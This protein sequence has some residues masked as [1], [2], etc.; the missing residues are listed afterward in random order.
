MDFTLFFA[1]FSVLGIVYFAVGVAASKDVHTE[2]DYFLANRQF[3]VWSITLTLIATQVGAGMLVGASSEAYQYGY[4]G[5]M[6]NAGMCLGFLLLGLGAASKLRGFNISTTAEI[7]EKMY[8]SRA[9]RQIASLL[10]IITLGGIFASQILASRKMIGSFYEGADG[11]ILGFWALVIIYTMFGGLRAV[12]A[13]DILQVILIFVI[14]TGALYW[15]I[16]PTDAQW[17]S[18]PQGFSDADPSKYFKFLLIPVLFAFIEQDLAQRFFSAKTK[19]VAVISA[20]LA[21]VIVLA[22]SFIPVYLG[23]KAKVMGLVIPPSSSPLLILIQQS[24]NELVLIFV[25]CALIAAI[26]STA[27]SLLCAVG[28]NIVNDFSRRNGLAISRAAT[29]LVGGIALIFAYQMDNVLETL[30]VSYEI[31]VSCLF[32]AIFTCFFKAKL[33]PA[34]AWMSVGLGF[35]GF[36]LFRAVDP[37][38]PPIVATLLLSLSG[39]IFGEIHGRRSDQGITASQ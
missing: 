6:Y 24:T 3:G 32:I 28:S 29:L 38:M 19:R 5:I 10:S 37:G 17:I 9:L 31:S 36:L 22:F 7:F 14:F 4:Y 2:D 30:S 1:I 27:D 33:Y 13:T 26:S 15:I 8:G 20:L 18:D 35:I 25:V 23:M 21:S 12:V 16:D 11:F 39:Y 34:A